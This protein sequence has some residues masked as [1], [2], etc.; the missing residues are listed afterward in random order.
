MVSPHCEH[1]ATHHIN[2]LLIELERHY[3]NW[4]FVE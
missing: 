1:S 4:Y 2:C 3:R